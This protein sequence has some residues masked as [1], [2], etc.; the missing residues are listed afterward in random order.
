[1]SKELAPYDD[2]VETTPSPIG[3]I[4][5]QQ[6]RFR[7]GAYETDHPIDMTGRDWVFYSVLTEIGRAHV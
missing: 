6:L 3:Y 7:D 2:G 5:G 1:M 4:Y